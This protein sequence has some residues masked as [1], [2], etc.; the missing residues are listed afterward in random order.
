[1]QNN[2]FIET[3]FNPAPD[4]PITV[5]FKNGQTADYTKS[6]LNLLK[7]DKTID[8]ITDGLTGEI[9]YKND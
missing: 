4:D 5:Y 1:M 6:I 3:L 2:F 7:T 8:C 9:I